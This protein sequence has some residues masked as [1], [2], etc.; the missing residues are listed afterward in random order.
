MS[1]AASHK[2]SVK[3][4]SLH[5]YGQTPVE[6]CRYV[7]LRLANQASLQRNP[8]PIRT[9]NVV[10]LPDPKT[11]RQMV[12]LINY[13]NVILNQKDQ[14]IILKEAGMRMNYFLGNRFILKSYYRYFMDNWG[15]RTH[16]VSLEAPLKITSF[17]SVSPFYR[18]YKQTAADFFLRLR[19]YI[20]PETNTTPAIMPMRLFLLNTRE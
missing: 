2:L 9:S 20:S 14:T 16:T 12:R 8:A 6:D 3:R 11:A 1:F 10:T 5:C 17:V 18:C 4:E 15:V 13:R 7:K 19:A